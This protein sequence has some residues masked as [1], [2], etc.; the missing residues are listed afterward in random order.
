MRRKPTSR[1]ATALA[2][3]VGGNGVYFLLLYPQLPASWQHQ[4]FTLDRGLGLDF[5]L[6]LAL[7]GLARVAA[8]LT[9]R[10]KRR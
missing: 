6:C 2:A 9:L 1:A 10:N 7:Y 8:S 3:V 4:P 5:L